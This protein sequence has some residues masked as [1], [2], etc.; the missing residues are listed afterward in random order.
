MKIIVVGS[1]NM[2]IVSQVSKHPAPGETVAGADF[3]YLPGGK[4]ANQAVAAGRLGGN[5]T[6]FG[7]VG[8]DAFA[9]TL[10]EFYNSEGLGTTHV[11]TTSEV[12]TGAAF[13]AVDEVGE[14]LIYVSAGANDALTSADA[15]QLSIEAGDI[16]LATLESPKEAIEAVFK[17]AREV[18]ATTVLNAAPAKLVAESLFELTDYLIVN[19]TEL[20]TFTDSPTPNSTEEAIAAMRELPVSNIITTLGKAGAV[21]VFA[22]EE[23]ITEGKTVEVVDSTGAGDCFC[24]AFVVALGEQQSHQAAMVFANTAASLSVQK[25][26]AAPSMPKRAEI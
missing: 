26:G 19:E 5:V 23:I 15:K 18:G 2:D 25:V 12:P 20:A 22:G 1:I 21:G 11:G 7:K 6:L 9:K 3:Q 14:N 13:V 17:V 4:G 8:T 10:L 16:V 24:G